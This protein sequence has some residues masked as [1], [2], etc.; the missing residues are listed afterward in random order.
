MFSGGGVAG[1]AWSGGIADWALRTIAVVVSIPLVILL[2]F[3]LMLPAERDARNGGGGVGWPPASLADEL[4]ENPFPAEAC[5][6]PVCG[7]MPVVGG[8]GFDGCAD[9][10]NCEAALPESEREVAGVAGLT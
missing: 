7:G 3:S 9:A 2:L 10:L 6:W 4:A 8:V 1:G 5:E